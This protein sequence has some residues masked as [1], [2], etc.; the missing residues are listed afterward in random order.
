MAVKSQIEGKIL[1]EWEAFP[2]KL[3]QKSQ[4]P[5]SFKPSA[6]KLGDKAV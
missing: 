5:V 6:N 4:I 1:K 2:G 3:S